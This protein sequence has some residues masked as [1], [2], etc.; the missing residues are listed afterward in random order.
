MSDPQSAM[1]RLDNEV[2]YRYLHMLNKTQTAQEAQNL[3]QHMFA[4]G[5]PPSEVSGIL[6]RLINILR[7]LSARYNHPHLKER[8]ER[9]ETISF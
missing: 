4:L 8:L 9:L 2:F 5:F 3:I 6:G 1:A 7:R